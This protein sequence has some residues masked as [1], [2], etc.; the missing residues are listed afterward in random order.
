MTVLVM[1]DY[2]DIKDAAKRLAKTERRVQ[3]MCDTGNLPGARKIDGAWQIPYSAHVKFSDIKSPEQLTEEADLNG[4]SPDKRNDA[5]RK[6]GHVKKAQEF[7]GEYVRHGGYWREGMSVYASR[8][9][10]SRS[11]L[12]RWVKKYRLRGINGLLDQRGKASPSQEVISPD[13]FEFFRGMYLTQQQLSVRIC[14][15]NLNYKSKTEKSGWT[16]PTYKTMCKYIECNIP[17]PVL[18]LHREGL[19][20]YEA[21]CA[22]YIESDPDSIAPG[23]IWVGDHHQFNCMIWHRGGWVRP[24]ITA[25]EDMRSRNIVGWFISASPNQTTIMQAMRQGLEKYGPPDSVKIDNGRDYDSE[26]WTGETKA[27]RKKRKALK[28]GYIDEE[29]V[30]GIYAMMGIG[31]SFAKPY[32]PQSKPIERFFDTLDCQFTKTIPTYCGK[33]S[34]RKPDYLNA[35]LKSSKTMNE[36]ESIE[37]FAQKVSA[38]MESYNNAIHTGSGMNGRTPAQVFATRSSRRV[39]LDGTLDLLLQVWSGERTVGKNGVRFKNMNYGQY[40]GGLLMHHGKKVRVSYDPADIRRISVYDGITYQL[41]AIAEQN[42]LIQYGSAVSEDVVRE[43]SREKARA[44]KITKGY[45]PAQR[46]ANM[47]ITDLTAKALMD[48]REDAPVTPR[49]TLKPV[50]TPLDSQVQDHRRRENMRKVKKAAG[51]ESVDA[52]VDLD[53]DFSLLS[54]KKFNLK[55]DLGLNFDFSEGLL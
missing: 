4:F 39:L 15:Q 13:A 41:L 24:W 1:T 9:G 3:Q 5:L 20:A 54:S 7:A 50:S 12:Y 46:I 6:I 49:Q 33:D 44:L 8:I 31:V 14:W 26:M 16:I 30:A 40:D 55:R 42:R 35:L 36:A 19:A 43:A 28:A 23:S 38:Y 48:A 34:A 21:K 51:A 27:G 32:H 17:I 22:P 47:D 53:I 11:T 2:I 18:V 10:V 29:T 45:L 52:V 25:W 37:S